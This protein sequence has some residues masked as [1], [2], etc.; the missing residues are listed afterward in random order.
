MRKD[1][2]FVIVA[3]NKSDIDYLLCAEVLAR[4]IK[5]VMPKESVTLIT[6]VEG[7]AIHAE[8]ANKS[9][10]PFDSVYAVPFRKYVISAHWPFIIYDT[11]PFNVE[12]DSQV[13]EI[14]PYEHTIKLEADMYIPCDISWWFDV[15]KERD[16]V[17]STTIRDH[18]NNISDNRFYRRVL[19]SNRLPNTYNAI[20]YFKKSETA[21]HFYDV[22][23][24]IFKNWNEYKELYSLGKNFVILFFE[25]I[26]LLKSRAL[27]LYFISL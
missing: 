22:V 21:K 4:S 17:I 6:D 8:R 25:S 11:D 12:A 15:L 2:G 10:T 23:K 26:A 20:T 14:S 16:L 3:Q 13:Y 24:N 5:R 19:D 1:R 7:S 18:T 9:A 27:T